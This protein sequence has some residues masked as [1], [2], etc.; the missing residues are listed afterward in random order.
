MI[1]LTRAVRVSW[2]EQPRLGRLFARWSHYLNLFLQGIAD[3]SDMASRA[4]KR[5]PFLD[6]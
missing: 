5:H 3:G 6:W 4:R 1:A 2:Q